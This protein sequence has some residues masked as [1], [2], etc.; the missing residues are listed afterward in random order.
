M[1][2]ALDTQLSM[3]ALVLVVLLLAAQVVLMAGSLWLPLAGVANQL[4]EDEPDAYPPEPQV[5]APEGVPPPAQGAEPEPE[6]APGPTPWRW[7]AYG[8]SFLTLCVAGFAAW[9]LNSYTQE[10]M[11]WTWV[12]A[13][14]IIATGVGIFAAWTMVRQAFMYQ[15]LGGQ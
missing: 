9:R 8:M 4:L 10:R 2:E 12:M 7:A 3:A 15:Q 11:R 1:D 13:A 6:P 5:V 14:G